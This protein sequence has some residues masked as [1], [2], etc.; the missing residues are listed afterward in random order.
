MVG[1]PVARHVQWAVAAKRIRI[2]R[3]A[4]ERVGMGA[5]LVSQFLRRRTDRRKRMADWRRTEVPGV[6]WWVGR[7]RLYL[8][9]LRQPPLRLAYQRLKRSAG[10]AHAQALQKRFS[11]RGDAGVA[12]TV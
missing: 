6:A 11:C 3:Y 1:T 12:F 8:L 5:R 2:V 9:P 4:W 7:V 10:Q